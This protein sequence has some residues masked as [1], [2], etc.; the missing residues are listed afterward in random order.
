MFKKRIISLILALLMLTMTSFT[1][2]AF[3]SSIY[4]ED[5]QNV[6]DDPGFEV[7]AAGYNKANGSFQITD[8]D[9]HSGSKSMF[10][11]TAGTDLWW[12]LKIGDAAGSALAS[13]ILDGK[14]Y[15]L[16]FWAKAADATTVF[17]LG[18]QSAGTS[19]YN[20]GFLTDAIAGSP[21]V[22][23]A[24]SDGWTKI[25]KF[26]KVAGTATVNTESG[27]YF[28]M[29]SSQ[30]A[31]IDDITLTPVT[32]KAELAS[33]VIPTNYAKD[34]TFERTTTAGAQNPLGQATT[35]ATINDAHSG[36][37]VLCFPV[38]ENNIAFFPV[39]N[40]SNGVISNS[41]T[42]LAGRTFYVSF[43]AKT[44]L[45]ETV[46]LTFNTE[47]YS[48]GRGFAANGVN[49]TWQKFEGFL[50]Y[51]ADAA[52]SPVVG[53]TVPTSRT[54][55][56]YVD[57]IDIIEVTP[58]NLLSS[59][60]EAQKDSLPISTTSASFVTSRPV[61]AAT[62]STVTIDN[63]ATVTT[64]IGADAYTFTTTFSGL[65]EGVSYSLDF[66]GVKDIYGQSLSTTSYTFKMEGEA[67][68]TGEVITNDGKPFVNQG[69]LFTSVGYVENGTVT[70]GGDG[71]NVLAMAGNSTNSWGF[72][73]ANPTEYYFKK[74][75][76]ANAL[77]SVS[78]WAKTQE[79][80]A[81]G[82]FGIYPGNYGTGHKLI[83]VNVTDQWQYFEAVGTAAADPLETN[84]PMR[85]TGA[86]YVDDLVVTKLSGPAVVKSNSLTQY[87]VVPMDVTTAEIRTNSTIRDS[88]LDAIT[89]DNNATVSATKSAD[90]RTLNLT[91]GNLE[92]GITYT[93]DLSN[94]KDVYGQ[95]YGLTSYSFTMDGE[96]P[97]T[98][99]VITRGAGTFPSTGNLL[100]NNASVE[101]N[102]T[103]AGGGDGV[104]VL[105]LVPG[106]GSTGGW[107][108]SKASPTASSYYFKEGFAVGNTYTVS[109]WARTVNEGEETSYTI[110]TDYGTGSPFITAN[111]T[112][113]WSYHEASITVSVARSDVD[114][115]MA[116]SKEIY[117][118]DLVMTKVSD[119]ARIKSNTLDAYSSSKVPMDLTTVEIKTNSEIRDNSLSRITID[120]GATVSA[121]KSGDGRTL[122]LT[123]G[124]LMEG[125]TYTLDLTEFKDVYGQN[126][127][128]L[129][130]EFTMEGEAPIEALLITQD[131]RNKTFPNQGGLFTSV[132]YV[133]DGTVTGGGDGINVLHLAGE[134]TGK[135]GF[136]QANPAY[137]FRE[138][139]DP[140]ETYYVSFW[141]KTTQA[142]ATGRFGIYPDSF[143]S[144]TKL[145]DVTVTDQWQFFEA[146]GVA[147][148]G[149]SESNIPMVMVGDIYVDDLQVSKIGPTKV[150]SNTL[151]PIKTDVPKGTNKVTIKVNSVIDSATL[152][153]ATIN[154]QATVSAAIGENPYTLVLTLGNLKDGVTYT[155]DLSGVTDVYTQSFITTYQF[156]MEGEAPWEPAEA[157]EGINI[158]THS[159][160][161]SATSST[162]AALDGHDGQGTVHTSNAIVDLAD[163][164][165][166]SKVMQ[167]TCN[168]ASKLNHMRF[169]N[170]GLFSVNQL[171]AGKTYAV[172]FMAKTAEDNTTM[173]V[174]MS[175][176]L[177]ASGEKFTSLITDEWEEFTGLIK[178]PDSFVP[179]T[180]IIFSFTMGNAGSFYMDD[181]YV[182]E[183]DAF[184]LVDTSLENNTTSVEVKNQDIVVVTTYPVDTETLSTVKIKGGVAT[185]NVFADSYYTN[186]F[187]VNVSNLT[188]DTTYTIDLSGIKDIYGQTIST[189]NFKFTTAGLLDLGEVEFSAASITPG[190]ITASI[191]ITNVS[192]TEENIALVL[193]AYTEDG[194]I[195]SICVDEQNIA[196]G[197]VGNFEAVVTATSETGH[198]TAYILDWALLA[199]WQEEVTLN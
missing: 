99:E 73:Q 126:Y 11:A 60:I 115:P 147:G 142:G 13:H 8:A 47:H 25:E 44:E 45:N 113:E 96:P 133:E 186:A 108:T 75:F 92:E 101:A 176:G 194:Y 144:N 187:T 54:G 132:G 83:Q 91:F 171:K 116:F 6:I 110:Y 170:S 117:I 174:T 87:G 130:Y 128:V 137:F 119:P 118:D 197:A 179:S 52:D 190:D 195:E 124:K 34:P 71:I 164:P 105:H 15:K 29:K 70:G 19:P 85:I 35:I 26:I 145:I 12:Q 143:G 151:D 48:A 175:S 17:T 150:Y 165:S 51:P 173:T 162:I 90:G 62:L 158:V 160:F 159:T 57:D 152:A 185:A 125:T 82:T 193:V 58:M 95:N 135:W 40:S 16:S 156:K 188:D 64:A 31:Y 141:A 86:I 180:E 112:N 111:L 63:G 120:K 138:G 106:T 163:A 59:S 21:M 66:S 157:K 42:G 166:G 114:I 146:A 100:V 149:V 109:F 65:E 2:L 41:W 68:V 192:E 9:A 77:Y 155:L 53:F 69:G 81:T 181:F 18:G 46:N 161:E 139:F 43:W 198:I 178:L 140:G 61:N 189:S 103:V 78:F 3:D 191:T 182:Y 84:I 20:T 168:D 49:N 74:G 177:Y 148:A 22:A 33:V 7:R 30:P 55:K 129:T 98:G 5:G 79:A 1:A 56:V 172:S 93:L 14:I 24:T 89:I 38:H 131:D 196:S 76:E 37:N 121:V 167:V 183:V 122:V 88:A 67:P 50:V 134:S 169:K 102:N 107:G 72:T 184:D 4:V 32:K 104:N 153:N 80:G 199:P 36:V 10:Y 123:L 39:A 154:K 136:T 97:V 28:V 127:G 94:F 27:Q 23:Y